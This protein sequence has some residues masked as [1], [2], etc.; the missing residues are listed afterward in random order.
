MKWL[1]NWKN[2]GLLNQQSHDTHQSDVYFFFFFFKVRYSISTHHIEMTES[3]QSDLRNYTAWSH[4]HC[5][6]IASWWTSMVG[7]STVI[8]APLLIVVLLML[9]RKGLQSSTCMEPWKV[10]RIKLVASITTWLVRG[11]A[12]LWKV[13]IRVLYSVTC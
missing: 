6:T 4:E 5:T 2:D 13:K 3:G 1:L 9:F 12:N 8:K 7:F 10:T 11:C